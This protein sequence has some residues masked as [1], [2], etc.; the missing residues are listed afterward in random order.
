[1]KVIVI[2]TKGEESGEESEAN[3]FI[4]LSRV[5]ASVKLYYEG[6]VCCP[7]LNFVKINIFIELA[8][9]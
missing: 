1:M 7:V 2:G 3:E 5:L 4:S 9:L 6:L 8:L